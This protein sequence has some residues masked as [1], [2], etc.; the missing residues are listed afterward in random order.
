MVT[1]RG[2]ASVLL[3]GLLLAVPAGA[4]TVRGSVSD[5][6]GGFLP[7]ALV[8]LRGVWCTSKTGRSLRCRSIS[9]GWK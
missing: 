4:A 2:M 7:G 9:A 6:T 1:R 5:A 3:G 8:I